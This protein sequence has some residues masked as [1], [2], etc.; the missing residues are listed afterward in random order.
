MKNE[1]LDTPFNDSFNDLLEKGET[2]IWTGQPRRNYSLDRFEITILVVLLFLLF[3]AWTSSMDSF[4]FISAMVFFFA[5]LIFTSKKKDIKE[6][7]YTHYALSQK[8]I[9]YEFRNKNTLKVFFTPIENIK[10][11]TVT[12]NIIYINTKK[13][14]LMPFDLFDFQE[15][16]KRRQHQLRDID[17]IELVAQLIEKEIAKRK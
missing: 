12:R 16:I 8:R 17:E 13:K 1:I 9:F 14:E 7:K 11:I 4:I 3:F 15:P 2:I 6:G 5:W 10:K